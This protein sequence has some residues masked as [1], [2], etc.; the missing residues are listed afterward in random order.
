MI[1]KTIDEIVSAV[2]RDLAFYGNNGGITLSGGE[3]LIHGN[4]AIELLKKCK[5][6]NISTAVETCGYISS[7]ILREAIKY[8]DLFLWDIKDTDDERHKKYTG[9]SN[10]KIVENLLLAD[11]LGAK[12]VMRCIIVN[13][14]NTDRTHIEA[15][16]A[17]WQRLSN[18]RYVELLPYHAYG[19]SKMLPLGKDDNGHREWIPDK[20]QIEKIK[21]EL[22]SYG[23]LLKE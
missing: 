11:S 1:E 19:G 23:V 15:L 21:N 13:G 4:A 14:V 18:C 7:D 10:K 3:P 5:E 8:T 22:R 20:K 6:K 16:A 17:L 12:T 9:V 2:E